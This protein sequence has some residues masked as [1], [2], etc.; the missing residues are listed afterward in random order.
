M[1]A[2]GANGPVKYAGLTMVQVLHQNPHHEPPSLMRLTSSDVNVRVCRSD[3][4]DSLLNQSLRGTVNIHPVIF[5]KS[6]LSRRGVI[7]YQTLV[8]GTARDH[9][10]G[11]ICRTVFG[12]TRPIHSLCKVHDGPD[13]ARNR[14]PL[15]SSIDDLTEE[16]R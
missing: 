10:K 12:K 8:S 7:I 5:C 11:G 9:L 2:P 16:V 13:A 15:D 1:I 3:F 4:T 14:E 6:L